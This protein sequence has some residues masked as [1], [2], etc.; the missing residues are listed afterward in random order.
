MAEKSST[1]SSLKT[2]VISAIITFIFLLGLDFA[3]VFIAVSR[4]TGHYDTYKGYASYTEIPAYLYIDSVIKNPYDNESNEVLRYG[5][6]LDKYYELK[7]HFVKS[8]IDE[9]QIGQLFISPRLLASFRPSKD[10][11]YYV[12]LDLRGSRYSIWSGRQHF[13][14]Y[15]IEQVPPTLSAGN[16]DPMPGWDAPNKKYVV[17]H[18]ALLL[19]FS[20][21]AASLIAYISDDKKP[22]GKRKLELAVVFIPFL[23]LFIVVNYLSASIEEPYFT[24][25]NDLLIEYTLPLIITAVMVISLLVLLIRN[26]KEEA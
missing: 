9:K 17:L 19:I 6:R 25:K 20:V 24:A 14:I 5:M 2:Y 22:R 10:T 13:Q 23:V 21:L 26:P 3:D 18:F 1:R 4:I 11:M 12:M 7:V 16:I 15:Y 8:A